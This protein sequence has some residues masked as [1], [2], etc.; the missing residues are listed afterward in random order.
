MAHSPSPSYKG[1]AEFLWRPS[2]QSLYR[3]D[4]AFLTGSRFVSQKLVWFLSHSYQ[5]F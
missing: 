1:M 3:Q 2:E 4:A 5:S